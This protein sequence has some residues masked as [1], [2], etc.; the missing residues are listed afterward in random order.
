MT[1]F[2][3]ILEAFS[4][5]LWPLVVLV[6]I[7]IVRK[8]IKLLFM[9]FAS[10]NIKVKVGGA[11]IEISE[12]LKQQ[13]SLISEL[14]ETVTTQETSKMQ[15]NFLMKESTIEI[16]NNI[17]ERNRILWVDDYP[18]NNTV[19]EESFRNQ[20][21]IIDNALST[22]QAMQMFNQK[23]YDFIITDMGRVEKGQNNTQA[24]LSLA[25]QIRGINSD[26]PIILF[27]TK[28]NI[29]K[30]SGELAHLNI[31]STSSGTAILKLLKN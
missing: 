25:E 9:S 21:F 8:E 24:G 12:Y 4:K 14:Q 11:E 5:Y 29:N 20:G 13:A 3:A 7:I 1:W 16:M 15:D 26:I 2:L 30:N 19:L 18:I 23:K 22:D 28:T 31:K 10:K 17:P 27:T 6:I